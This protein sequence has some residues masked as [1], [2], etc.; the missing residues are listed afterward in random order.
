MSD[1]RPTTIIGRINP[2]TKV[3]VGAC[4]II[5]G[6]L[7]GY[8]YLLVFTVIGLAIVAVNRRLGNFI[9][10]FAIG[11]APAAVLIFVLDVIAMAGG[12]VLWHWAFLSI[13]EGGLAAAIRFTTRFLTI[14]IGVMIIMH[15][16]DMRTF[17]RDLE[18]RGISPRATYVI[19]STGLILPQLV[20]RGAVIMDAQRARGIETDANVLVR[21][22]ALVPSAAPLILSTLTGVAERAVSLEARGMTMTGPRTSL[23]DVPNTAVDKLLMVLALVALAGYVAWKVWLWTR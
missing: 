7:S 17:S 3:V 1:A 20:G 16:S 10:L 5:G 8:W 18:Q 21:M 2:L 14:G 11:M 15:V 22:K 19:Q 9:K 13:T 23:V 4:A 6:L 12:Q